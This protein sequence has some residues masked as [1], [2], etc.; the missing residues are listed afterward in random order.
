VGT[1]PGLSISH[2]IIAALGGTIAVTSEIGKGTTFVV[3]LP[4][5]DAPS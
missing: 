5:R 4:G 1:G 3:V 2:E